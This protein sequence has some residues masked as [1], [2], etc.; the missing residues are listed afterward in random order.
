[1]ESPIQR[2]PGVALALGLGL[3]VGCGAEP[4]KP[5]G[6]IASPEPELTPQTRSP[7][8][9]R[10]KEYGIG[11]VAHPSA[12]YDN[13]SGAILAEPHST[14]D[15]I[16]TYGDRQFCYADRADC[17]FLYSRTVEYDYEIGGWAILD[18]N[19]DSSWARVSIDPFVQ[20][21]VSTGWVPLGDEGR[22]ILWSDLLPSNWLF[23]IWPDSIA[24]FGSAGGQQE[25]PLILSPQPDERR[26][27]YSMRPLAVEG[28][29]LQVEV[30]TPSPM[31]L[32]PDEV[33][34]QRDTAWI[35]YLTPEL[36]PRAFFYT[37]GC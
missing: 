27:D 2:H 4:P 25:M 10:T 14:A 15:T 16:A 8:D 26:F 24:F 30:L 3:I 12:S 29:W 31:C 23:F 33:R 28:Q 7:D 32:L 1:M 5:E 37:R 35:R 34:V 6:Q 17:V 21:S 18:F 9:W 20:D 13:F 22:T 11:V 19:Q 36:R